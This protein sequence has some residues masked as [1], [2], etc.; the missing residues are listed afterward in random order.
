[1]YHDKPERALRAGRVVGR[2]EALSRFPNL[3][4]SLWDRADRVFPV[5]LTRSWLERIQSAD[6]P[7]ARQ[8]LPSAA[9]L[10]P[11]PGDN[12]DPVGEG[13]VS[14]SPWLVRKHADRVLFIVTRRCHLYCR[15]CFRRNHTG[16]EDPSPAELEEALRYICQS[17]VRELILSGGD[18]L[19]I[20]DQ[21]LFSI[22]DR[23]RPSVPVIRIHTRAPITA[24][25]RMT[26]DLIAGLKARAPVWVIV[27]C[28]HPQE[29]SAPVRAG[30]TRLVDAGV[31][32]LNQA[33]LLQ[34]VND[35]P[36]VLA[37]LCEEL[38]AL[39]VFPYYLHHTDKAAGNADFRVSIQRGLS[40]YRALSARVSGIALPRYVID[41]P[42]GSGK[43]PVAEW[44]HT[45]R[46]EP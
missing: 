3:S 4:R 21:K 23:V 39:R 31:P 26:D 34:G 15:Y 17:G 2:R 24:P 46:T 12:T 19:A 13:T 6:D 7:L 37:T 20:T 5:R 22:L 35:D 43:I 36:A 29:L 9:E 28:N 25:H 41:R 10:L 45:K 40:I 16:A 30:L 38:V 27:H 8:V 1:M 42:D 44:V 33:V 18:P 32:V 14:P 11:H